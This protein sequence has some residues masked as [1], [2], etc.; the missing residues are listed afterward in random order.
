MTTTTAPA[1][2]P[3]RVVAGSVLAID[4]LLLLV[5]AW[6]AVDTWYTLSQPGDHGFTSLGY[7]FAGL[8]AF[9]ALPSLVLALLAIRSR[10]TVAI[11]CAILSVLSLAALA[12]FAVSY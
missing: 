5:A 4:S 7:F 12:V 10:G 8:F 1:S 11:V 9:V 3:V 6:F 2:T